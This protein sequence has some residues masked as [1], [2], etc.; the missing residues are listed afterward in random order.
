M[1]TN[2]IVYDAWNNID[3]LI[4]WPACVEMRRNDVAIFLHT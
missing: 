3:D 1:H 4:Y 2:S